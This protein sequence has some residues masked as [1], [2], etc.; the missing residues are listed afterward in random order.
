MKLRH[1]LHLAYCTNVHRGETWRETF[2]SLKNHALNVREKICPHGPFAIGLRLSNQAATE[3]YDP[4]MLLEFQ[5][6]LEKNSC[7]V[8]T[9]NGFPYGQFHGTRVKEQ[10]YRPDWTSPERVAYTN[11]LFNLLAELLPAGIEGSVSTLPGSF[12]EFHPSLEAQKIIR[13][14]L[15]R[16]VEH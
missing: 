10:V 15:W 6:W 9:I 2:A 11:L 14:N 4:K 8:F 12:K 16:S 13:Q 3:L 7:Y 1:G 5:R